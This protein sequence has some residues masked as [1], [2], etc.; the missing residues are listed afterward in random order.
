[1]DQLLVNIVPYC[2]SFEYQILQIYVAVDLRGFKPEMDI[3]R[4]VGASLTSPEDKA[5]FG[6]F[7]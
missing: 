4:V 3:F 5:R 2:D 1:V 6:K 7:L